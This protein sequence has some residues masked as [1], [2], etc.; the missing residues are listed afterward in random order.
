MDR[1][2]YFVKALLIRILFLLQKCIVI[3]TKEQRPLQHRLSSEKV[4]A[5]K[6]I[7]LSYT[8]MV[9]FHTAEHQLA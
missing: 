9:H 2:S 8:A 4:D 7:S 3:T 6:E 1:L 5:F